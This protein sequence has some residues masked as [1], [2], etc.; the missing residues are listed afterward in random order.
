MTQ[1]VVV[2]SPDQSRYEARDDG[3][4]IGVLDYRRTQSSITVDHVEV[5]PAMR[6]QGIGD[7]LV[8]AAVDD[9][10]QADLELIPICPFAAAWL[11]RNPG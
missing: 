5:V 3:E 1:V 9:A 2:D 6:G 8:K 7:L 11:A 10:R 4:L